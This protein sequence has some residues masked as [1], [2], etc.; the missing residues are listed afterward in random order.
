MDLPAR[1]LH[2]A[3]SS[4][5]LADLGLGQSATVTGFDPTHDPATARRLF[6]LGFHVGAPVTVVRRS[7]FGGPRVYRVGDY[8][9]ALRAA[10]ARGVQVTA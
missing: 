7:A 2:H 1:T 4:L 5:C 8:E 9:L 10:D 6:D 3:S